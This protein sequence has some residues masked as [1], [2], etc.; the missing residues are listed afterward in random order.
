MN[1]L[2]RA[3]STREFK[4]FYSVLDTMDKPPSQTLFEVTG[5]GMVF[6]NILS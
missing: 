4:T 1:N 2:Q 3:D 6:Y 5:I